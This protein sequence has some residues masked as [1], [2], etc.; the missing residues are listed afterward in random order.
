MNYME[1]IGKLTRM[2][3]VRVLFI[4]G[5]GF[6]IQTA[7]FELL[8]VYLGIL[9]ASTAAVVGAEVAILCNFTLNQRF[10]FGGKHENTLP[11]WQRILRFHLVVSGSIFLQWLFIFST[12]Q[13]TDDWLLI[14]V[15]YAT[16][17][18]VGFISNYLGYK[19]FVW[20][21]KHHEPEVEGGSTLTK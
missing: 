14:H 20:K 1:Q 18:V 9:S 16:G 10:S 2:R 11:F 21:A 8:A 7:I 3:I 17:V 13:F 4:G 15:A 19:L 12:E 5:I 6:I